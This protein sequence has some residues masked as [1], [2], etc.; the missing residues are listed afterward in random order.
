MTQRLCTVT[1]FGLLAAAFAGGRAPADNPRPRPAQQ[2]PVVV[3]VRRDG[4]HWGDAAI[5]AAATLGVT[6]AAGG[7]LVV[8]RS[9]APR[10]ERNHH[11]A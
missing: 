4:F 2:P 5:G 8:A 9:G 7:V 10:P 6:L 1:A 11:H 3:Q